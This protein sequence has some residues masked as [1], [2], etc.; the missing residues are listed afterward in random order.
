MRW[1][2]ELTQDCSHQICNNDTTALAVHLRKQFT[3]SQ[4]SSDRLYVT[5]KRDSSLSAH[6]GFQTVPMGNTDYPPDAEVGECGYNA[7]R[8]S[9]VEFSSTTE[10]HRRSWTID[11][12]QRSEFQ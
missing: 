4:K 3:P 7:Y 6:G 12:R 5:K 8:L 10:I 11:F 2:Q 1:K 9:Q